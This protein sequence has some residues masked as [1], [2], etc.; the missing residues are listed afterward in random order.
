MPDIFKTKTKDLITGERTLVMGILNFTPDS[1][2][3][4]GRYFCG[5]SAAER[6]VQ[7]QEQGA[8]IIDLGAN[9]TRPGAEILSEAEELSRLQMVLPGLKA[10]LSVPLS[11]DTFYPGTA[12]FALE[13]GADIINDVSG[14]FNAE[15]AALVKAHGAGLVVTHAPKSASVEQK[16]E[17]GVITDVRAFFI[18]TIKA[19]FEAGLS[20]TQL[21]LD[22]GIGFGKSRADDAEILRNLSWLKLNPCPLLVGASRKRITAVDSSLPEG[23]DFATSAANAAA[24]AG[25]ADIIRVHNVEAGVQAARMAD[26][27]FRN[28]DK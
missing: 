11:V 2:S 14:T 8:D 5:E 23:R 6:A 9:S 13:N 28:G 15:I 27:I 3:D 25:G 17:N 22:P 4:G 20:L 7:L 26:I 10:G 19:A 1:F 21:C 24:V 18:E 12:R 16:Y